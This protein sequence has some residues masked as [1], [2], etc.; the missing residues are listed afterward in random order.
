MTVENVD[1]SDKTLEVEKGS[2]GRV[3]G[4]NLYGLLLKTNFKGLRYVV[5]RDT[6]MGTAP[7]Q[8]LHE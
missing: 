4:S 7:P 5:C 6:A 3:E 2:R 1:K 8:K